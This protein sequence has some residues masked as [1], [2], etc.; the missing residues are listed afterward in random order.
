MLTRRF[1]AL[2]GAI[3]AVAL[4]LASGADALAAGTRVTVR[5]EGRTHTLLARTAVRTHAGSITKGGAP[6]GACSATSAAGALDRATHRHWG[7]TYASGL[8]IAVTSIFS[9][10]HTFSSSYYWGV[11]VDNRYAQHG[12][13]DLKL[14][15]GEQLLFA[16]V[17]VK[18]TE[19]PTAIR[20]PRHANSGT[21]V[22]FH[23]VYF[24]AAGKPRPLAKAQ[25]RSGTFTT[26][27]NQAGVATVTVAKAGRFHF[28][29]DK[30]GYIRAARVTL[31]VS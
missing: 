11:W 8:G 9:E 4:L 31:R 21:L 23:V 2:G 1:I 28:T 6:A 30:K 24:D 17:P 7:G 10:R 5:V 15:R 22:R 3:L 20:A 29:A 19:H 26:A 27:T 14:H 16:A 25:L 18:G 12:I 13:C